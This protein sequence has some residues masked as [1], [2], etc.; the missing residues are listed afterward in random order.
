M[1]GPDPKADPLARTPPTAS[2]FAVAA[3]AGHVP[4]QEPQEGAEVPRCHLH[5]RCGG[6]ARPPLNSC[7]FWCVCVHAHAPVG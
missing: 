6:C 7:M 5:H 4:A 3:A 2:F 1:Y